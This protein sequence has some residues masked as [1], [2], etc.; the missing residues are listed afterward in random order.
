MTFDKSK[1]KKAVALSEEEVS[2]WI[3]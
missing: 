1:A 3:F 2:N